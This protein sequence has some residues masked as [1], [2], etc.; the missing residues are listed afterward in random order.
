MVVPYAAYLRV[1]QPL[2][3]FPEPERSAWAK[4]V[5]AEDR[6][7]R[8]TATNSEHTAAL[9]RL[10][11]VP[12]IVVPA[13]E[14]AD[15]YVRRAEGVT[16]ICPWQTRLRSWLALDGFP[17][18]LPPGLADAFVP[19]QIADQAVRDFE[20]WQRAGNGTQRPFIQT[21]T[22]HVPMTWFVPFEAGER[23]LVL[24]EDPGDTGDTDGDG[25]RDTPGATTAAP[26]RTLVYVTAMAQ[27]RRRVA[28]ALAVVRR[29][30]GDNAMIGEIE[31]IG[32]WLEEFHPHSLVELD[33]GGLV[34]LLD[35]EALRGDQS[36]AEVA[37]ALTGLETGKSELALGMYKRVVTR[38]RA[39]QALESAN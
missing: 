16:Y 23:W 35:D 33:Y 28:R 27:A 4:Y 29:N 6:P 11:A 9:R 18:D 38:W 21:S 2:A 20:E 22:W 1:Y 34:H 3:A 36:V 7:D 12:P 14:S 5:A 24:G 26:A 32:R 17:D 15:A 30:L 39:V 31:E 8:V 25:G 19:R 37:A 10:I 13:R